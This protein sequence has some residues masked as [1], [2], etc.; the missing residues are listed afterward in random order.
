MCGICG[1]YAYRTGE[2][3][4]RDLIHA[5]TDSMA[6]RGPDGAGEYFDDTAGI[7]FGHRRL[8]II[9]LA[10][11][12]QPMTNEDRTVWIVFNGEIYNYRELRPELEARGHVFSTSSDTE[13]IIH[14]YEE[15]GEDCPAHFNGIFAFA[16][17][18]MNKRRLFLARD[19]FGIK[20]LYY[21]M[22]GDTFRFASELK[23]ILADPSVP[24]ELDLDS[25]N[26]TLIFR[27]CP[28]PRTLFQDVYKLPPSSYMIVDEHGLR[29]GLYWDDIPEID[30]SG[31]E[32]DWV[33]A[34]RAE[35]DAAVNRQ[36]VA[37]VPIGISLSSGVDSATILA[38]MSRHSSGPVRAYTVD[39]AGRADVDETADAR[40]LA[41]RFGADFTA[42]LITEQDY[43]AFMDRYIWHMEEPVVNQS[44]AA[45]YFVSKMARDQ[46]VKVLLNGQGPDE[47]FAGY[48]RHLAAAHT[49]QLQRWGLGMVSRALGDGVQNAPLPESYRR[50]TYALGARDEADLLLRI[51]ATLPDARRYALF[52][53]ETQRRIDAD[54]PICWV[55]EQLARAPKGTLLEKMTYLDARTGLSEELLLSEDKMSMAASIEARVP[56]LDVQVMKLAE[57]LPGDVK[58]KGRQQKAIHKQACMAWVPDVAYRRK[59]GFVSAADQWLRGQLGRQFLERIARPDSL[60]QAYLDPTH[61]ESMIRQHLSGR[62]DHQRALFL[63]LSLENW[64]AVYLNGQGV[65]A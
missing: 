40:E 2:P 30:R 35:Y 21:T 64:F 63:L 8:S 59:I 34:L 60:T 39:F 45:Y 37:D 62:W 12:Q 54:L 61:V 9:D 51:Y 46:G 57:R 47:A 42:Q 49:P 53:P 43:A 3:A 56:Y 20:P 22:H 25:L 33:E 41:R 36:M 48:P 10:L 14:A 55:R 19:H 13:A 31:H 28:A 6:H 27:Y 52:S 24:R 58:I 32:E 15:Y 4:S 16:I 7:G 38:L 50:L 5:M 1:T 17:W 11:G 26:L 29:Q 23:A 65:Y 18:D 44:A